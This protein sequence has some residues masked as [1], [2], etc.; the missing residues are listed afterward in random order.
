MMT[1][2]TMGKAYSCLGRSASSQTK[3][4]PRT[5]IKLVLRR[6]QELCHFMDYFD[7]AAA[8]LAWKVRIIR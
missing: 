1:H 5:A 7:A 8:T 3:T 2:P 6:L 4:P